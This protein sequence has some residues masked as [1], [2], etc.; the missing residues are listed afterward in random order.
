MDKQISVIKDFV[1][2]EDSA[3]KRWLGTITR[4]GT[5]YNY[6]SAFRAYAVFARANRKTTGAY[7]AAGTP[8]KSEIRQC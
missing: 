3:L 1:D 7:C 8:G 6:R 4:R 5:R 2:S